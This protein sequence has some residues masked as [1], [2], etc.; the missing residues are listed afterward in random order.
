MINNILQTRSHTYLWGGAI[1]SKS[2]NRPKGSKNS[3]IPF[4]QARTKP[5][6][7]EGGKLICV[8][9]KRFITYMSA[10]LVSVKLPLLKEKGGKF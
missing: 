6:F 4:V 8:F 3:K 7:K 9:L 5:K 2:K 10:F 1:F